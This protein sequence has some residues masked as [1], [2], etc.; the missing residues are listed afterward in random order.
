[1]QKRTLIVGREDEGERLDR[2]LAR[3]CG[4]PR[5]EVRRTLERGG[6]WSSERRVKI[7]SRSVRMGESY[8]VVLDEA[9]RAASRKPAPIAEARILYEDPWLIAVDKPPHVPAQAT[10][11]SDRG[12]LLALVEHRV[13]APVG[14]VHRLDLGTSGVTVFGKRKEATTKLAEAFREGG[15][16]KRYLALAWGALP[17]TFESDRSIGP[18]PS[19]KGKYRAD[20]K[21]L[22]RGLPAFTAFRTLA[23]SGLLTA[24]EAM[25]RTG[26]THQIRAQLAA[27]GAPLVGDPLYGGPVEVEAEG[28]LWPIDRAMLHAS[29]LTLPHPG[30]GEP[31]V[32]EAPLP[33]DFTFFWE[34]LGL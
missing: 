33:K 22:G 28:A 19:R 21:G 4:L 9:G 32:I 20:P 17:D 10:L 23:R 12:S 16:A 29:R 31:L 7:A 13:G 24:V 25:P 34:A 30:T 18:D 3:V 15:A 2:Y 8:V 27:L 14:L 6:V 11:A 5:G 1:M 26:R